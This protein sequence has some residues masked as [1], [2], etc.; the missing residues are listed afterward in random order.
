MA[1]KVAGAG[2]GYAAVRVSSVCCPGPN[3]PMGP[4]CPDPNHTISL[5]AQAHKLSVNT[6]RGM[7]CEFNMCLVYLCVCS[8]MQEKH[9]MKMIEK[10]MENEA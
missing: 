4:R 2:A 9:I 8:G 6:V 1:F 5:W 3:H 10:H 7:C